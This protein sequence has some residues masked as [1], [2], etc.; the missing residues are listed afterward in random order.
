VAAN[1]PVVGRGIEIEA[2]SPRTFR[3][4]SSSSRAC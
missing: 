1:Q 2:S 3:S 4:G